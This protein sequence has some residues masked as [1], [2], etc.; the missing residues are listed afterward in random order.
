MESSL[1]NGTCVIG[2]M[3]SLSAFASVEHEGRVWV[4][5]YPTV[6]AA[7]H[8]ANTTGLVDRL[9]AAA[10]AL[11]IKDTNEHCVTPIS[12]AVDNEKLAELGFA[13][14]RSEMQF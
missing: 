8:E 14:P 10:A 3:T 1:T 6:E 2:Q 5:R 4:K 11:Y 13:Q 7:I 9:F 12:C